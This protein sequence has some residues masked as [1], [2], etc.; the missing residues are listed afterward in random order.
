M[1]TNPRHA[2]RE[3]TEVAKVTESYRD[4]LKNQSFSPDDVEGPFT[5]IFLAGR[6]QVTKAVSFSPGLGASDF[7]LSLVEAGQHK[8]HLFARYNLANELT[9]KTRTTGS[10]CSSAMRKRVV[11]PSIQKH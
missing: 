5:P 10:L 2:E 7:D 6:A 11:M 8:L 4:Q 1:A 3:T 9:R